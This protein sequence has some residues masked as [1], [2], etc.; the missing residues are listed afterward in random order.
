M[1]YYPDI[2][3][4]RLTNNKTQKE[5]ADYLHIQYQ[6]YQRYENGT[7]EIPV[8]LVVM[9]KIYYKCS[10]DELIGNIKYME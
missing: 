2:K 7:R 4:M 1:F 10:F 3:K 6:Q 5:I 9:L 8:H